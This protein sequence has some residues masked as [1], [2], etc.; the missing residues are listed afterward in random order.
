M[1]VL[2]KASAFVLAL[3]LVLPVVSTPDAVAAKKKAPE[4]LFKTTDALPE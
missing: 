1:R 4:L 2:K 3:A